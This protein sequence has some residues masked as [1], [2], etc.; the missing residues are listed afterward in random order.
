MAATLG[1]R[2]NGGFLHPSIPAHILG[3]VIP[4]SLALNYLVICLSGEATN[5]D[6]STPEILHPRR[7]I[8]HALSRPHI[9]SKLFFCV[10]CDF[11]D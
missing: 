4:L 5:L 6:P 8:L 3:S 11:K 9:S 7:S 10:H 1:W 2:R